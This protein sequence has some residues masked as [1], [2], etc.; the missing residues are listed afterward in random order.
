MNFKG[1]FITEI[2]IMLILWGIF[3]QITI[4]MIIIPIFWGTSFPDADL[5]FNS[6]RNIIFHS[7]IP[8]IIIW[9]YIPTM[10]NLLFVMAVVIHLVGDLIPMIKKRG[11]Y[12][13][14]D[15]FNLARLNTK[16]SA[17]WL[18]VNI[19]AGIFLF[20]MVI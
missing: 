12:A 7:I 4:S 20:C 13:C 17:V 1:H 14:I 15:L 10:E 19:L 2:I 6:H 9:Y 11:G 5:K 18:G 3:E 16:W 8:N